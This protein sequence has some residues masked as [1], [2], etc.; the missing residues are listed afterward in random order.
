MPI[1][2]R[3]LE[4]IVIALRGFLSGAPFFTALAI[5]RFF[6]ANLGSFALYAGLTTLG[7]ILLSGTLRYYMNTYYHRVKTDDKQQLLAS[8]F[9]GFTALTGPV[10]LLAFG[11]IWVV[12]APIQNLMIMVCA[13]ILASMYE[14]CVTALNLTEKQTLLCASQAIAALCCFFYGFITAHFAPWLVAA[15]AGQAAGHAAALLTLGAVFIRHAKGLTYQRIRSATYTVA[16][17]MPYGIA[18]ILGLLMPE[19]ISNITRWNIAYQV[20]GA[21]FELFATADIIATT[22]NLA[23]II[24]QAILALVRRNQASAAEAKAAG[25]AHRLFLLKQ[26]KQIPLLTGFLITVGSLLLRFT[27][28]KSKTIGFISLLLPAFIFTWRSFAY[29][30]VLTSLK[31]ERTAFL[32]FSA[33]IL[34]HAAISTWSTWLFGLYGAVIGQLFSTSI[35]YSLFSWYALQHARQLEIKGELPREQHL[36]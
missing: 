6:A 13:I 5:N 35:C 12:S 11:L 24:P 34:L 30:A 36:R 18:G 16:A 33:V 23:L 22:L 7:T 20:R 2:T 32:L 17:Q 4:S 29:S 28:P 10:L 26:L 31:K 21:L 15:L 9:I 27:H 14:L 19:C 25:S 3:A 1:S 8:I